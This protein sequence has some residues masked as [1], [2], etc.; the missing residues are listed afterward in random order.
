MAG[1]LCILIMCPFGIPLFVGIYMLVM[2]EQN[3]FT[4]FAAL[5]TWKPLIATP[6]VLV[7]GSYIANRHHYPDTGYS[8]FEAV[9]IMSP[10]ILITLG[11]ITIFRDLVFRSNV[12][13]S[14]W[15][16]LA[17]DMVRWG[18]TF[19]LFAIPDTFDLGIALI[20]MAIGIFG[21]TLFAIIAAYE[22]M[23]LE[24]VD[25][26]KKKKKRRPTVEPPYTS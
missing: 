17:L 21:P 15:S 25:K 1:L 24:D 19:V 6:L 13:W 16:L 22:A 7:T 23:A 4:W 20:I 12:R 18:N 26:H 11:L 9:V 3:L 5:L 14:A 10:A 2:Y 8:V